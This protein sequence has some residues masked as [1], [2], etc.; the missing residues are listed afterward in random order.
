MNSLKESKIEN[1][2]KLR[3]NDFEPFPYKFERTHFSSELHEK[4]NSIEPGNIIEDKATVCGRV[5]SKRGFGKINFIDVIDDK[6]KIQVVAKK[7]VADAKSFDVLK[8]VD[9][10]DFIGAEGK[11]FKTKKGELSV[12]AEKI[13]FLSKSI[14]PLPEKF[15]GLKDL[16]TRHRNRHIDLIINPDV[17]QIFLT[18]TK[19][20]K[21]VRKFLDD[22]G[23][24]EVE[25]PLLQPNYGGAN[26][27]PFV[28]KSHAW[29]SDFFLSISPELDLKRLLVGG[30]EKIYISLI[31]THFN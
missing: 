4:Y 13:T 31:L 2:A 18:R 16:E 28:T 27:R 6:G 3:E 17:K 7:D 8:F 15:H 20:I 14:A 9:S 10:G 1:L 29:K 26:A 24:V 21:L 30:F 25:I 12:L 11:I 19:I 23:F 5:M 22:Q